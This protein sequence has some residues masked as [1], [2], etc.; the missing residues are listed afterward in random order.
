MTVPLLGTAGRVGFAG[1]PG[2]SMFLV[3]VV[4]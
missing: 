1:V 2:S 4:A 3:V